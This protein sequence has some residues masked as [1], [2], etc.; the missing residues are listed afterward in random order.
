MEAKRKTVRLLAWM[1]AAA[2]L[3]APVWA[4]TLEKSGGTDV[5]F[6]IADFTALCGDAESP[7]AGIVITSLPETGILVYGGRTLMTGEAVPAPTL[8]ALSYHPGPDSKR[9]VRFGFLPVYENGSVDGAMVAV[10]TVQSVDNKPPLAH[11]VGIKTYK[12]VPVTG[13]FRAED[14]E[15]D[16]LTFRI[17]AKPRRGEVEV[18]PD[19][20]FIYTPFRNKTGSDILSYVAVDAY[21]NVSQ[22]GK[23]SVVIEK[24]SSKTT[25]ADMDGHP[26][27]YAAMRLSGEEVFTGQWMSGN[28]YFRPDDYVSRA[29]MVTM[30]VR[31]IGLETEAVTTTGFYD[32]AD[33][34]AWFKPYAQTALKAGIVS[35]GRTP[36][37]RVLMNAQEL[38]TL[39]QAASVINNA[40]RPV[41]VPLDGDAAVPAW[42]AQ[43]IANLDAAGMFD[44]II[45]SDEDKPLTRGDVA[46]LLVR[47]MDAY[48]APKPE[49]GLLS[50]VFGW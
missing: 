30:L 14:P 25:Y 43:A 22:E 28:Y 11:D 20:R 12:N 6:S 37:G 4:V 2:V 31:A 35:G 19:G 34:P 3:A 9:T 50:W 1:L 24:P 17:T 32:D 21:G 27:Q 49:G 33:I 44:E 46:I 41:N 8:G 10:L 23:I 39:N 36:D 29:E 7:L 40:L 45:V 15:G 5:R 18:V 48:S 13:T 47:A 38:I 42:S 16:A 26:A